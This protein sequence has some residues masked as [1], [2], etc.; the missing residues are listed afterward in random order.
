MMNFVKNLNHSYHPKVNTSTKAKLIYCQ[1][2]SILLYCYLGIC[3]SFNSLPTSELYKV[4]SYINAFNEV[5]KPKTEFYIK[6]IH[7]TGDDNSFGLVLNSHYYNNPSSLEDKSPEIVN[8]R[9]TVSNL[10]I[11]YTK[12]DVGSLS[13]G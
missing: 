2:A 5:H 12:W 7:G 9:G 6:S 1:Y 11:L 8:L 4:S 10:C 13:R 3:Y